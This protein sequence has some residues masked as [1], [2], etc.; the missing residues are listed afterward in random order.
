MLFCQVLGVVGG[1]ARSFP[2][3]EGTLAVVS[4]QVQD[5]VPGRTEPQDLA[6]DTL[7]VVSKEA[8]VRRKEREREED[9]STGGSNGSGGRRFWRSYGNFAASV[10]D[11]Q[12]LVL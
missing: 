3:I 5:H 11:Y 6:R 12:S 10:I 4:R 1:V 9:L 2:A 8:L 7:E